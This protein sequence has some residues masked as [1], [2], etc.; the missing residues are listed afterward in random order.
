MHLTCLEYGIFLRVNN[1]CPPFWVLQKIICTLAST[2][3]RYIK[4]QRK[5]SY[6]NS[7]KVIVQHT[8]IRINNRAYTNAILTHINACRC[9]SIIHFISIKDL[10]LIYAVEKY[11]R[12][13][14][15]PVKTGCYGDQ[16][17]P[18]Q[19]VVQVCMIH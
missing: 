11:I 5:P 13:S 3:K 7:S 19:P 9:S 17:F 8:H 10:S 15:L 1:I 12:A 4:I 14:Q 18:R 2:S 6:G 16:L